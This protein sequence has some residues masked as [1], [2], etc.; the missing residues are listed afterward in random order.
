MPTIPAPQ[1]TVQELADRLQSHDQFILLDVRE[2]WELELARIDDIRLE[3]RPMSTLVRQGLQ[4]L[5]VEAQSRDAEIFVLCHHGNRSGNV[6]AWLAS[7]GWTNVF[8]VAG[9]I[10][11]YARR[12]DPSIPIY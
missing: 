5:S 12:I 6:S 8:N 2:P 1:M 3:R 9:G 4:A 11:A 10:D 7:Q